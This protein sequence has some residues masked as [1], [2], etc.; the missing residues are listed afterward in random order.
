MKTLVLIATLWTVGT[1][2]EAFA[3]AWTQPA[4]G[5]FFKLGTQMIRGQDLREVSGSK[6]EIPTLAD[7]TASLYAEY[8]LREGLTLVGYLPFFK[9]ITLNRQVGR[10]SGF[11]YFEGDDVTGIGDGQAGL[12][13]RLLQWGATVVS[14]EL[15]F[16]VP[17]GSDDQ[18]NGLLT[19]DGEVNQRLTLQLGR[20]LY[21]KPAYFNI[22]A[23]FNNRVSG[24]SDELLYAV[25][26]GYTFGERLTAIMRWRG[27]ESLENGDDGVSG[28]MGG[29]YANDQSYM[30]LGPEL[31]YKVWEGFGV[32]LGA[33][34]TMRARNALEAPVWSLGV[35]I[36]R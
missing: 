3:G 7:Y 17:L 27:V 10:P 31:I 13:Y 9:R 19:G 8:G 33:A 22:D 16:G 5:G 18:A 11:V 24:Y 14:A 23:G 29:L 20:S 36:Q 30:T 26:A 32:S 4:G 12:R 15:V 1:V 2:Q 28:G 35:F 25:E 6:V 21:P 34:S